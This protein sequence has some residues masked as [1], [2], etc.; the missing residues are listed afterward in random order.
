MPLTQLYSEHTRKPEEAVEEFFFC[1]TMYSEVYPWILTRML[2]CHFSFPITS[3]MHT[4]DLQ[5]FG[6]YR[7]QLKLTRRVMYER[8]PTNPTLH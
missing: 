1:H 8:D 5:C 7:K 3:I 4:H 2:S 6:E